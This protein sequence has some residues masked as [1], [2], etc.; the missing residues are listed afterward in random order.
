M[1]KIRLSFLP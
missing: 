1:I